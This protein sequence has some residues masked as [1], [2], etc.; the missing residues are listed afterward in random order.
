MKKLAL[1]ALALLAALFLAV[2]A[3]AATK[4]LTTTMKGGSA[5]TPKGDPNGSGTAK[6]TL[7]T[8]TGKIC[9]TLKW[10]GIGK[11][12]AAHIHK[13]KKG[14]AGPVVVPLFGG[15]PKHTG[16]VKASKSLVRSIVKGP[17]AYY[18]NLHTQAFPGG[19]I[20]GQL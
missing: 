3:F 18:V 11:P 13:G 10:S 17:A 14:V 15:T 9:F 19:A 2:S 5:E 8:S 7:N 6:F 4:T 1:I 12:A 20:R 16:C